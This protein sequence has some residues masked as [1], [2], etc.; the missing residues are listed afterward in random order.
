MPE[1]KLAFDITCSIAGNDG[2]CSEISNVSSASPPSIGQL[3]DDYYSA[4]ANTTM[5]NYDDQFWDYYEGG[6]VE[7]DSD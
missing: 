6:A 4:D 5:F 7:K 3:T 2:Y 1:F